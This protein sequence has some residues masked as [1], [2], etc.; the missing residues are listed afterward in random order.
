MK[1]EIEIEYKMLLTKEEYYRL[2]NGLPFPSRPTIQTNYYFETE[3]FLLKQNKLAL[4][5]REKNDSYT[6][7]LKQPHKDGVLESHELL[8]KETAEKWIKHKLVNDS[9]ILNSLE[10]LNI[11]ANELKYFGHLTTERYQFEQH[12]I[13][14]VLDKSMYHTK[15][16]YE[17][18]IEAHSKQAAQKAFQSIITQFQIVEKETLPKITRFFNS[19][20]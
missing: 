15:T 10:L 16:D 8:T 1:Q 6:L 20:L 17:L 12:N 3:T 2:L 5:I 13:I 7:T 9:E 14:Y 18:E 11:P 4:R 19:I